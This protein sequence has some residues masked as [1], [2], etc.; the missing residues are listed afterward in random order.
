MNKI[1]FRTN[2]SRRQKW[3]HK[4]DLRILQ[5]KLS[6]ANVYTTFRRAYKRLPKHRK[7]DNTYLGTS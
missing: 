6:G 4:E 2:T 5:K 1:R 3:M 7:H